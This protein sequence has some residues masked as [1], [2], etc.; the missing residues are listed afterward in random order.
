MSSESKTLGAEFAKGVVRENPILVLM[1]GLCP[2]LAVTTSA[3]NGLG[4]GGATTFVL[5]CSNVIIALIKDWVPAKVR[6][7][8]FI[9]VIASFVTVV[10]L[11]MHAFAPGLHKALGIFVP[12]IVVNCVILGRA[13]AFASKCGVVKSMADALGMGLGF[14]LV[15]TILGAVREALGNGTVLAGT[16][17][18]VTLFESNQF[19]IMILAP[20]AFITLGLMMGLAN[21][22]LRRK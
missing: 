2:A 17:L 11:V 4:M 21:R 14:T 15:L 16:P 20:G 5:L 7:P 18:E 1:L 9:V 8:V 3:F 12:L 13:E 22:F 19:L 10:D 6:I